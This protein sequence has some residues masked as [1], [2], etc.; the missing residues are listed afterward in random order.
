[1]RNLWVASSPWAPNRWDQEEE[2]EAQEL[3]LETRTIRALAQ[4][5]C[6]SLSEGLAWET[7][8]RKFTHPTAAMTWAK[9][10]VEWVV[11]W[12]VE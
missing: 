7:A 11:E 6:H 4:I 1:V 5:A 12:V 10:V 9:A 2:E 8:S 3:E